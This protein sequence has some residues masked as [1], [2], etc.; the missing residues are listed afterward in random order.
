MRK[1]KRL[2]AV[3]LL[4]A[5]VGSVPANA[6]TYE[7]KSSIAEDEAGTALE[8][9]F[10][11]AS[12]WEPQTGVPGS[13]YGKIA[14]DDTGKYI[15]M[16]GVYSFTSY[17]EITAPG[18]Y[19]IDLRVQNVSTD[20]GIVWRAGSVFRL[21]EWD[22][23]ME[24]GGQDGFSSI[25]AAG[26]ILSPIEGGIRVSVK[27]Q[28]DNSTWGISSVYHD[29]TVAG[30]DW[31]KFVPIRI[32][33]DGK[34]AAI[35]VNGALLATV[36]MANAGE[37]ESDYDT[38]IFEYLDYVYYKDVSVKDANGNEVIKTDRARLVSERFFA[39]A[40]VR[41]VAANFRNVALRFETT[42]A[43]EAPTAAPE[44]PTAAPESTAPAE[45]KTP[46]PTKAPGKTPTPAANDGAEQDDG[47]NTALIIGICAGVVVLAAAIV[48]V[49][50][51]IRKKGQ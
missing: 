15:D 44:S 38:E 41:N 23:H 21:Y 17:D 25:G 4:A 49:V 16:A 29:F 28:D 37:Y 39:G 18:E 11:F 20:I 35:S 51:R 5:C 32:Q 10:E 26:I 40:A 1:V 7:T 2:F 36:S 3:L 14:E 19:A 13:S 48:A 43:T 46:V 24:K 8:E 27:T 12:Y 50:I 6:A 47:P 9:T 42:D 30:I 22:F 33:D 45:T 34:T 31:T